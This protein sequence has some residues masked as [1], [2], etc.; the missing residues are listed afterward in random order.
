MT[1]GQ[2]EP[3]AQQEHGQARRARGLAV[4][5][6]L[7]AGRCRDGV[8]LGDA[9]LGR[10]SRGKALRQRLDGGVGVG[11]R[12]DK[13]ADRGAP[14][15]RV[16]TAAASCCAASCC[17]ASSCAASCCAAACQ[18]RT[19]APAGRR[20]GGGGEGRGWAGG[21]VGRGSEGGRVVAGVAVAVIDLR[22]DGDGACEPHGLVPLRPLPLAKRPVSIALVQSLLQRAYGLRHV[23]DGLGLGEAHR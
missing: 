16:V 2:L 13:V 14:T 4:V 6:G 5:L 21:P 10:D 18:A 3:M 19:R 23:Q 22:G 12:D 17:A 7:L 11:H 1:G 9:H 20:E 15:W 8:C